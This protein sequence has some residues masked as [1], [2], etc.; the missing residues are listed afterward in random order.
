MTT[1]FI[2]RHLVIPEVPWANGPSD[3]SDEPEPRELSDEDRT[4]IISRIDNCGWREIEQ[5]G[6][7]IINILTDA[8]A[9]EDEDGIAEDRAEPEYW[10]D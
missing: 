10:E 4:A 9:P 6:M 5:V 1:R 2:P 8:L 7:K 3:H